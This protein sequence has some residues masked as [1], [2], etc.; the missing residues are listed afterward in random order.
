MYV[1][2]ILLGR[3]VTAKL[4]AIRVRVLWRGLR[5]AAIDQFHGKTGRFRG[6]RR[7]EHMSRVNGAAS[8]KLR[9]N[10]HEAGTNKSRGMLQ[11]QTGDQIAGERTHD[12]ARPNV[13]FSKPL[14]EAAHY[15]PVIA[16]GQGNICRDNCRVARMRARDLSNFASY[17][18]TL[19]PIRHPGSSANSS[20]PARS[21]TIAT[22]AFRSGSPS[23]V[24]GM[25]PTARTAVGIIKIPR[26]SAA[27]AHAAVA[28]SETATSS[29]KTAHTRTRSTASGLGFLNTIA[30][31]IP[32][33]AA[34]NRSS[35][36]AFI[37]YPPTLIKSS[38]RPMITNSPL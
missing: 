27:K 9:F 32:G 18:E 3:T 26:R 10:D 28:I 38:S 19:L 35:I 22:H 4:A 24:R 11:R 30:S 1:I 13:A 31:L 21:R 16:I 7:S 37:L 6:I 29:S 14:S 25:L 17:I 8:G 36:P 20:I 5:P 12:A 34:K 15:P 23:A 33:T 2:P